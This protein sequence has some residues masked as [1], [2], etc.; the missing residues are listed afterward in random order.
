MFSRIERLLIALLFALVAAGV[1]LLVAQA[2][3]GNTPIQETKLNCAACHTEF[4]TTWMSGPHGTAVSDPIFQE[5][6]IAQGSPGG[7]SG[8][9]CYWL[10]PGHSHLGCRWRDL[11]GLSQPDRI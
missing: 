7:L 9:P 10:R 6:W 3:E 5:E 1:T 4:Q 8:L 11:R 2:Q